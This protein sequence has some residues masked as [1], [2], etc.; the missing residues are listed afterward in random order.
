MD[1][2]EK[3]LED[4]GKNS[5]KASAL[6]TLVG[7]DGFVD[8]IVA[9]V[10]RRMGQGD[11][12][13]PIRLIGEFGA[14]ISAAAGK[15][16]NIELY[17]KREK[18]G[19]NAPIMAEALLSA[20][21]GVKLI[22]AL[23]RPHI[24]PVFKDL[25]EK[26]AAVSITGPGVTHAIEF[27]DGKIMLGMMSSLDELTYSNIIKVMGEG[28]FIDAVS[29]ADLISMVNWT[30]IPNM[31]AILNAVL[32]RVLPNLGPKEGGRLFYF[33]LADPEKRSAGDLQG[34]LKTIGRFCS[35]GQ[36]TLGL[37][38][39]EAQRIS[40]LLGHEA[41]GGSPDKLKKM[42]WAIRQDMDITCVV[43]HPLKEA[44]CA[45]KDD[46]WHVEGPYTEDP[47]LTTGAGDHFNAGFALGQLLRMPPPHCLTLATAFSGYYVFRGAS[48][49]LCGIDAFIRNQG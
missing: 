23:G 9:P 22:G 11:R 20:G 26:T 28:Q 47:V 4:L 43:V 33:D 7:L 46:A 13:E 19:G 36:V 34:M 37:N 18:L 27:S 29:R 12:F 5:G 45:T 48:P 30:M 39:K 25:A 6:R 38:L 42:A 40:A 35:Y 15:S 8:R 2:K 16:T 10:G 49:A 31:T 14:R 17:L 44:A 3:T 1:Y 32:D 41:D 21:L 24:H